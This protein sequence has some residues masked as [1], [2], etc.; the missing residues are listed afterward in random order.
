MTN[1][2]ETEKAYAGQQGE[3][4]LWRARSLAAL[5]EYNGQVCSK[6]FYCWSEDLVD[7]RVS[8]ESRA[9]A[10]TAAQKAREDTAWRSSTERPR[11]RL[12]AWRQKRQS[13]GAWRITPPP[14]PWRRTWSASGSGRKRQVN[15]DC[16][17]P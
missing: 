15:S 3:C 16:Q 4:A 17:A 8:A 10:A 14:M 7:A 9:A 12:C 11:R 6:H 1:S 5:E 13:G 2:G